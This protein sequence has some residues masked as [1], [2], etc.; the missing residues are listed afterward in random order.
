[1]K[2]SR[3][4][5]GPSGRTFQVVAWPSR[6]GGTPCRAVGVS[7]L[8]VG[9]ARAPTPKVVRAALL[10]NA[11]ALVRPPWITS[12][13][14]GAPAGVPVGDGPGSNTMLWP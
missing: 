2:N 8:Q 1:M 14:Y 5:T 6:A 7:V 9:L 10:A 12:L 11:V 13:A 3:V 4:P